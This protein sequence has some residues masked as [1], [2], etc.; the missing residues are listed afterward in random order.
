MSFVCDLEVGTNPDRKIDN[1]ESRMD[2][3]LNDMVDA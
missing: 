3:L 2:G 1:D